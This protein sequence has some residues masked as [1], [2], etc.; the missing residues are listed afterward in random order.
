MTK[1]IY[2]GYYI[3]PRRIDESKIKYAPPQTRELWD[4]LIRKSAYKKD[5]LLD[6]GQVLISYS[7]VLEEL[8]WYKGFEKKTYSKT[9]IETSFKFLRREDMITTQKTTQGILVTILNYETYQN[10]K[11][12]I[13]G[14]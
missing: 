12:Y 3:K 6:R 10:L 9:Q 11:N 8:A 5:G 1:K 2:G 4:L 14:E 13:L 7:E